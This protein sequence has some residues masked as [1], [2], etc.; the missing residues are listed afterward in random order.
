MQPIYMPAAPTVGE[1][2]GQGIGSAL[3]M[4]VHKQEMQN[5]V[6]QMQAFDA[7]IQ[8]A[9]TQGDRQKALEIHSKVPYKNIEQMQAGLAYIN[10]VVPPKDTT[11]QEI[12]TFDKQTGQETRQF[13]PRGEV[14]KF[15]QAH[16]DELTKPELS[17]FYKLN[18]DGSYVNQGRHP[19][20]NRPEG[21]A[22]LEEL[23]LLEQ[24]HTDKLKIDAADRADKR[25]NAQM[26]KLA[27][28]KDK[29]Q[30]SKQITELKAYNGVVSSMLNLKKSIGNNGEVIIDFGGDSKVADA[31]RNAL[32]NGADYMK[33]Y[34]GDINK[35]AEAALRDSGAFAKPTPEA[36]PSPAT[37][38]GGIITNLLRDRAGNKSKPAT[39]QS[40]NPAPSPKADSFEVGKVYTDDKGNKAKYLGS[41]KWENQ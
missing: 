35:A 34:K 21:S 32:T 15:S 4:Y 17:D 33:K 27:E 14:V 29:E 10:Q 19:I 31:Y 41:N 28:T 1:A 7:A 12:S 40:A 8:Q 22:T 37:P 16:K 38:S 18:P 39:Q 25:F 5:Q 3:Q 30:A 2:V 9:A 24:Q 11:P 6:K 26:D 20:S 13:V 36:P 23:K